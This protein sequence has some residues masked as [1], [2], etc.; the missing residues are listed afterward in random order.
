MNSS[1]RFALLLIFGCS[2]LTAQTRVAEAD[3]LWAKVEAAQKA[4]RPKPERV[5]GKSVLT[6]E[7]VR[8]VESRGRTIADLLLRFIE[9]F[10]DDQRRGG[11]IITLAQNFRPVIKEIGDV[12]SKGWEAVIRD[13]AAEKE[14]TARINP[15][16]E[17]L[18]TAP[19]VTSEVKR[20]AYEQWVD[21]ARAAIGP[22][23]NPAE[24]RHRLDVLREKFPDSRMLRVGEWQ[25][26]NRLR[27][28]DP[29][30]IKPWLRQVA[31]WPQTEIAAWAKGELEVEALRETPL[32]LQFTAVDGRDVN[33]EKMRGKV[34]LLDF[35]ATWCGPCIAE[36]PNVKAV[37]E[38]YHQQ[39]FEVIAVSLDR[40][41][42]RQKLVD[43]VEKEH[44]P[45]PQHFELNEKGR[46]V[47][48][49]K[50]G[51]MAIPAMLLL[52]KSGRLV[53]TDARG[54]KL[55]SEVKRL[56]GL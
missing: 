1:I 31:A 2:V 51:I 5:D 10:P 47:L 55:E 22:D 28:S 30:A 20:S 32:E 7:Y 9:Q 54:P 8:A 19:G 11:A 44:L 18:L 41:D 53:A 6:A 34:V 35:W 49:D 36:L 40:K 17:G 14:W 23:G 46:N 15:L 21:I 24:F 38:R 50:Y 26:L 43:F 33:F 37:Y 12:R 4:E 16:V 56:L 3:A 13:D 27:K 52:D 42:D 25:Y 45:W 39:G 48:A 29:S